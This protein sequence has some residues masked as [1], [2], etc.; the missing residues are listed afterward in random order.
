M[1][2][3][4]I[5]M[6]DSASTRNVSGQCYVCFEENAPKSCCSCKDRYLHPTCML[7]LV[8]RNGKET[9]DVCLA[10]HLNLKMNATRRVSTRGMRLLS[11]VM[12]YP[13]LLCLTILRADGWL[14]QIINQ[15]DTNSFD[16]ARCIETVFELMLSVI[17]GLLLLGEL[18]LYGQ[19]SWRLLC[20]EAIVVH[21]A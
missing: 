6:V 18:F 9:C 15:S 10:P 16:A 20:V 3:Y 7:E 12:L 17:H 14:S 11:M 13:P 8:A 5:E 2:T 19:G 4:E 21:H 1:R